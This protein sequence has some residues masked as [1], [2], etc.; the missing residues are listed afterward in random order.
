MQWMKHLDPFRK[1][2]AKEI[3]AQG[4]EDA[5]RHL[6]DEQSKAEYHT[7]MADYYRG[8]AMRLDRYLKEAPQPA[9]PAEQEPKAWLHPVNASCVTTDPT[10]YARGIPLYTT[11][12]DDTHLYRQ[13][14]MWLSLLCEAAGLDPEGTTVEFSDRENNMPPITVSVAETIA[15][16]RQRLGD[17]K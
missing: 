16:L 8:V 1:P 13:S 9:K 12:P 7:K 14:V 15:A 6:L 2:T 17:T 5:R 10:A 11:P 4:L 3:A